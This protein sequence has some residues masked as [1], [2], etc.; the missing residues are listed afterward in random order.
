MLFVRLRFG[1]AAAFLLASASALSEP[2]V[3]Q[4]IGLDDGDLEHGFDVPPAS[5]R[6]YVWWHWMNGNIT[7]DGIRKD[8]DWMRSV[9]IGGVQN[10][11]VSLSTPTIVDRRLVYMS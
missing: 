2:V 3:V 10:F 7:V 11:D 9:D 8:L 6:P 4:D 5:A 1:V